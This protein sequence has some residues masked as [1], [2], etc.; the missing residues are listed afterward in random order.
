MK[1]FGALLNILRQGLKSYWKTYLLFFIIAT[2]LLAG[3]LFFYNQD[4]AKQENILNE[5]DVIFATVKA[6]LITSPSIEQIQRLIETDLFPFHYLI[7]TAP[8][9][10]YNNTYFLNEYGTYDAVANIKAIYPEATKYYQRSFRPF[11]QEEVEQAAKIIVIPSGTESQFSN[12]VV[13][14]QGESYQIAGSENFMAS[15]FWMPYTALLQS[16]NP[17]TQLEVVLQTPFT[18]QQLEQVGVALE[19]AGILYENL[20]VPEYEAEY[21]ARVQGSI[22]STLLMYALTIITLAYLYFYLLQRRRFSYGVYR[23]LGL[24]KFCGAIYLWIENLLWF[25]L[26]FLSS[27]PVAV[28]PLGQWLTGLLKV[29][30]TPM[31]WED[32]LWLF[33]MLLLIAAAVMLCVILIYLRAPVVQLLHE[34]ETEQ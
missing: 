33:F 12:H 30:A 17:V 21:Q 16:R 10:E 31:F 29:D 5:N 8:F 2:I 9:E 18:Q 24:S 34:S 13:E 25:C 19:Q 1:S 26:S 20:Q 6:D 28:W 32:I 3:T 27:L 7:L 14:I 15:D 22:T 4:K 11:T 23:M